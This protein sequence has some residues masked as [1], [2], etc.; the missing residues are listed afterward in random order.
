[1]KCWDVTQSGGPT[2]DEIRAFREQAGRGTWTDINH[3]KALMY[4]DVLL[5]RVS[6]TSDAPGGITAQWEVLSVP[7]SEEQRH[8]AIRWE[9]TAPNAGAAIERAQA[10]YLAATPRDRRLLDQF[11]SVRQVGP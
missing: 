5:A 11:Y 3:I 4:L 9:G 2:L 6:D 7:I 8:A 10:A 1:M